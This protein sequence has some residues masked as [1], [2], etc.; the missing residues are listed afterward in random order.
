MIM[1]HVKHFYNFKFDNYYVL[2]IG[3][4]A[5]HEFKP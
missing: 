4:F 3:V 2:N 1:I 5:Y